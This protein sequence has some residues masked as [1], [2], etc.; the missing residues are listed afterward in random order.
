MPTSLELPGIPG[1]QIREFTTSQMPEFIE[2]GA[3]TCAFMHGRP[4]SSPDKLRQDFKSFVR[5][6]A[7]T[8]DSEIHFVQSPE[9]KY[10]A[11]LWLH[12]IRNVFNRRLEMWIWDLTVGEEFRRRGIGR[13]LL[14]YAYERAAQK[15]CA[16][17]WLLVSSA[18]D[19]ALRLYESFGLQT[20]GRLMSVVVLG[21]E[22]EPARSPI[23]Y[24]AAIRPLCP[25]DISNLYKLWGSAGLAFKPTGRDRE[26]RLS[27]HLSSAA[28]GGWGC[29]VD[30]E[31][32]AAAI[33]SDDGRKGWIERLATHLNYRHTG[34]AK[35]IVMTARQNL[36]ERE[37]L[38]IG[39]LIENGNVASRR[40]FE[41]CGFIS[42]L[43]YGY[44]SYRDDPEA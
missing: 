25:I 19:T 14:Q 43:N 27:R 20:S 6:Y 28:P 32:A 1:F 26:D 39:A 12:S 30:G 38:V 40:L 4:D 13:A 41:A 21:N 16:E 34:L 7:F 17:L 22:S 35:A 42:D 10:A 8:A 15:H 2:L 9:G 11:Q 5:D 37:V 3:P 36:M 24:S 31:L 44:F 18:N 23:S 29:F 33:V